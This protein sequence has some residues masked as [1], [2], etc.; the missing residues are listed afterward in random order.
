[1]IRAR[2]TESRDI[3]DP[4]IILQHRPRASAHQLPYVVSFRFYDTPKRT[5]SRSMC[6]QV[7]MPSP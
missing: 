4:G 7:L 1:M 5:A 2:V 3:H 6:Y